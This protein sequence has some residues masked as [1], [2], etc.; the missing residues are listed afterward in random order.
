MYAPEK[1][2]SL[3]PP[4]IPHFRKSL[5]VS[6]GAPGPAG[7]SWVLEII[8]RGNPRNSPP[9]EVSFSW[10][11]GKMSRPHDENRTDSPPV[12][13]PACGASRLV[14]YGRT[15]AGLQKYR[16]IDA[17]CRRQFVFGSR[18][19]IDSRTKA[20]AMNMIDA[21][22]PPGKIAEAVPEISRSWINQLRRRKIKDDRLG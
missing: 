20:I 11:F 17:K 15:A 1:E 16:C 7:P 10:E 2:R 5:Q 8:R 21:G 22:I 18:H 4:R 6:T 19:L 3:C 14:K 12:Q 13:C 9:G